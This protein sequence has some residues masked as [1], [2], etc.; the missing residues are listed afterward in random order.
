MGRVRHISMLL[1]YKL[2]KQN[3]V[4][5]GKHSLVGVRGQHTPTKIYKAFY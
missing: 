5:S 2:Q 1:K 4:G 3:Q